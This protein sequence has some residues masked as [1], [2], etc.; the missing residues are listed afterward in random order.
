MCQKRQSDFNL[1]DTSES[2]QSSHSHRDMMDTLCK[3]RW[4]DI[5]LIFLNIVTLFIIILVGI[6]QLNTPLLTKYKWSLVDRL[7]YYTKLEVIC[8]IEWLHDPGL[9]P[10]HTPYAQNWRITQH[11]NRHGET[12]QYG[13]PVHYGPILNEPQH[14]IIK[15]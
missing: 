3:M 1:N 15:F 12:I 6:T 2:M 10:L 13:S 8:V 5:C 11:T 9:L 14:D 7:L 4:W